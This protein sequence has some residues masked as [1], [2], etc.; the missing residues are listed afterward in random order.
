MQN[1]GRSGARS[2]D[3]T[4]LAVS[5][6]GLL[7]RGRLTAAAK[8]TTTT[9]GQSVT[10]DVLARPPRTPPKRH[11]PGVEGATSVRRVPSRVVGCGGR[12]G[13]DAAHRGL[14]RSPVRRHHVLPAAARRPGA[15]GGRPPANGPG[16]ESVARPGVVGAL[17]SRHR[18]ARQAPGGLRSS[19]AAAMP[20]AAAVADARDRDAGYRPMLAWTSAATRTRWWYGLVS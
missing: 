16:L 5:Q 11:W 19:G 10:I 6:R 2:G 13:Q 17:T 12:D 14:P 8:E 20:T 18:R 3:H 1:D 15:P 9:P 7:R 4:H